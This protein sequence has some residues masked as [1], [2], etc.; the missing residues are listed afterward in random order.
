LA[1]VAPLPQTRVTIDHRAA[2]VAVGRG[3]KVKSA[4]RSGVGMTLGCTAAGALFLV[5]GCIIAAIVAG[6]RVKKVEPIVVEPTVEERSPSPGEMS[7]GT[8]IP[9]GQG[10]EFTN[11]TT[12]RDFSIFKVLG[13]VTNNS[14]RSYST[15]HFVIT[16]YDKGGKLL[17]SARTDVSNL[18]DGATRKFEIPVVGVWGDEIGRYKI[19]FKGGM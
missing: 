1:P 6:G 17:D 5:G 3:D 9:A 15:A 13:E 2:P 19:E 10:F 14:G 8:Q 12:R 4:F 18:A 11:V 16:L 7:V